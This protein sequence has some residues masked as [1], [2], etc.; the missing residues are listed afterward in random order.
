MI[1]EFIW[2]LRFSVVDVWL[3]DLVVHSVS[4]ADGSDD[5]RRHR[6]HQRRQSAGVRTS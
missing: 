4:E 6:S 2:L 5:R 3:H 1:P